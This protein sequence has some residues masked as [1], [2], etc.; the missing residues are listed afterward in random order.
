M[1]MSSFSGGGLEVF[2]DNDLDAGVD[3]KAVKEGIKKNNFPNKACPH[4]KGLALL[5][6]HRP[7]SASAAESLLCNIG[8]LKVP[9]KAACS[10]TKS[11]S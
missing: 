4:R 6:R 1:T 7:N 11:L 8:K 5:E 10:L 9:Y 2:I 3:W